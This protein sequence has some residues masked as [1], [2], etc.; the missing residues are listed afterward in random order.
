MM[1]KQRRYHLKNTDIIREQ[2]RTPHYMV[3]D[4]EVFK[5]VLLTLGARLERNK[6]EAIRYFDCFAF[7]WSLLPPRVSSWLLQLVK[8]DYHTVFQGVN[9]TTPLQKY[10]PRQRELLFQRCDEILS[11]MVCLFSNLKFT[12]DHYQA[13]RETQL[14]HSN[15][16]TEKKYD[17]Y[18]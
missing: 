11:M 3:S 4:F 15:S 7:V 5:N 8:Q 10:T 14:Q 13:W 17:P 18:H 16:K 12:E 1:K 6:A 2:F 9:D